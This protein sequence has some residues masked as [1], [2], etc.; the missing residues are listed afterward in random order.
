M[1]LSQF[2]GSVDKSRCAS[3]YKISLMSGPDTVK[4]SLN[5]PSKTMQR[6]KSVP[7]IH[8]QQT[9]RGAEDSSP[10]PGVSQCGDNSLDYVIID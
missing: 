3:T 4:R 2:E 5:L 10:T 9:D 1:G 6:Q 7:L 8:Q